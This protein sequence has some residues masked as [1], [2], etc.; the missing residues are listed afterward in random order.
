M[1]DMMTRRIKANIRLPLK[2]LP[3]QGRTARE[4]NKIFSSSN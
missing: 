2:K 4:I 1:S 3:G